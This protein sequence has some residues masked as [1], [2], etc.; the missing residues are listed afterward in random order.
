MDQVNSRTIG[1]TVTGRRI[2]SV[3]RSSGDP[4]YASTARMLTQAALSLAVDEARLPERAGVLTP[5]V[6]MG[7]V[8]VERLRAAGVTL[9][10]S[11]L[12]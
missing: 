9:E 5:A 11:E 7:D 6:A 2:Q 12:V 8:L 4:G 1:Q 3:M 10:S